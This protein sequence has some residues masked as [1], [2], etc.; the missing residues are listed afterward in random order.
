MQEHC[1]SVVRPMAPIITL[2]E[3]L[4]GQPFHPIK[5]I[6]Q[7]A[8]QANQTQSALHLSYE[9]AHLDDQRSHADAHQAADGYRENWLINQVAKKSL[10]VAAYRIER[11][12]FSRTTLKI[13]GKQFSEASRTMVERQCRWMRFKQRVWLSINHDTCASPFKQCRFDW[14]KQKE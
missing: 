12:E 4:A 3:T 5:L 9:F 10:L 6:D 14:K 2:T 13:A 11:W 8:G 1:A 7:S